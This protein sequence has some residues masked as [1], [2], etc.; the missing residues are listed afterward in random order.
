MVLV[1]VNVRGKEKEEEKRKENI[2][3]LITQTA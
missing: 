3:H 1:S 2:V